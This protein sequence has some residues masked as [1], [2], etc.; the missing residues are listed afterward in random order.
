M[1][2]RKLSAEQFNSGCFDEYIEA[3]RNG[4]SDSTLAVIYDICLTTWDG[5][6]TKVT[7]QE[8]GQ[9]EHAENS[10]FV[11]SD[12]VDWDNLDKYA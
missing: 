10:G 1:A 6:F 7:P 12:D 4:C 5:D 2:V 9:I 8:R 11:G 3:Y